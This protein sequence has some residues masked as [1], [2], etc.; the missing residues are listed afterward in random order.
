MKVETLLSES[1]SLEL[2]DRV[3]LIQ[4]LLLSLDELSS[5]E[6]E[7]LWLDEAEAR[8]A[9]FDAGMSQSSS[10]VDV[11]ARTRVAIA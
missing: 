3:G 5:S 11:F 8:L 1:L 4:R 6:I 9:N 10:A 7:H 2:Q